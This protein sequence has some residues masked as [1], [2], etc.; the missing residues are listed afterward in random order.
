M[1]RA[2]NQ[3][4]DYNNNDENFNDYQDID[5]DLD[6]LEDFIETNSNFSNFSK[7]FCRFIL[8]IFKDLTVLTQ[9]KIINEIIK[10]PSLFY[11]LYVT[12]MYEI[13]SKNSFSYMHEKHI[14]LIDFNQNLQRNAKN[15]VS[16]LSDDNKYILNFILP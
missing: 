6:I 11:K 4:D 10:N 7:N 12:K 9:G 8:H 1:M 3:C 15:Q 14:K 16:I 5:N 13:Y 2:L